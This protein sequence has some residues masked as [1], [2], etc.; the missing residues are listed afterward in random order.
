MLDRR[1]CPG[2]VVRFQLAGL[3]DNHSNVRD[4]HGHCGV[5]WI[6]GVQD[7]LFDVG[8]YMLDLV[9]EQLDLVL[10]LLNLLVLHHVRAPNHPAQIGVGRRDL[11]AVETG[12]PPNRAR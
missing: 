4:V 1:R 8:E 12:R 6:T 3:I 5:E 7:V 2:T 9:L 11:P 10:K